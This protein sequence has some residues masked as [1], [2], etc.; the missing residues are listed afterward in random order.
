MSYRC[1]LKDSEYLSQLALL[2]QSIIPRNSG[3]STSREQSLCYETRL[4][5]S[6]DVLLNV[7]NQIFGKYY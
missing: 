5:N 2:L 1:R 7:M 6:Y 4:N 3:G